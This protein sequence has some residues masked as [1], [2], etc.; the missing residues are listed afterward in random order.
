MFRAMFLPI[1]RST[2]LYLQYLVV[3]IQV[4]AG[5]YSGSRYNNWLRAARSGDWISVGAR[6]SAPVQTDPGAHPASCTMGTGSFPRVK[7]VRGVT[8][9]PHTLLA[10]WSWKSSAI[11]LL[12]LW[13]VRPVQS[14]SA[15]T[16]GA[17]Y[18]YL[19]LFYVNNKNGI[20]CCF[21]IASMFRRKFN[22]VMI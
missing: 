10:P 2:S 18:R 4:A 15:C 17:L 19:Y 8:L 16:R 1:I 3:F 22:N 5:S 11:P 20:N 6:F 12:P 13:A 9:T 21:S 14:L 7:S